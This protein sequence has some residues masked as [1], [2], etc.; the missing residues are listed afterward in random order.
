RVRQALDSGAALECFRAN[1]SA[2]GGD[3]RVCDEPARLFVSGLRA[4]KVES[5]R[6]GFVTGVDATE[7]GFAVASIGGGRVRVEDEID[8]AVGYLAH[9]RH[10]DEVRAGDAL[11]TLYCRDEAQAAQAAPRIQAAY[12]IGA[13][14]PPTLKLIK[15]V[16]TT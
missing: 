6:A 15:E 2:Q 9:A 5:P 14:S 11:G 12:T 3:A 7:I 10:G 8:P 1:I 13:E 4:V 16:I